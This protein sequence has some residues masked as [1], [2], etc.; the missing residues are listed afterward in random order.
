MRFINCSYNDFLQKLNNRKIVQFGAS[1]AWGYFISSFPNIEKE[2]VDRTACIVDNSPDKQG[3][4]F[5]IC[6]R[7]IKVENPDVLKVISNYVILIAVGIQY[8]E[9][10]CEQLLQMGLEDVE[11]YSLPLMLLSFDDAD[12]SAVDKYFAGRE[13]KLIP[14]KIHSFWFSGEEKPDLYKRC[15]IQ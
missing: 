10:I 9:S 13:D 5:A 6:D 12:N 7:E 3:S 1:S 2:V 8:Q 11:C 15:I 4:F 14:A